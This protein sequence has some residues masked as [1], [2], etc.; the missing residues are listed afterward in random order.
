MQLILGENS[1]D[2]SNNIGELITKRA[3]E[4][5]DRTFYLVV[6][7][8]Y[9]LEA[10]KEMIRLSPNGCIINIDVVSL[11][12][13]AIRMVGDLGKNRFDFLSEEA[14]L[15]LTAKIGM[16]LEK[17]LGV[18]GKHVRKGGYIDNIKSTLC[19]LTQY[20]ISSDDIKKVLE[21][22]S[23]NLNPKLRNKLEDIL[24][25]KTEYELELGTNS[26][27]KE[28]FLI[29]ASE[30]INES[31]MFSDFEIYFDR[32]TGF[33][34][35]QIIFITKLLKASKFSAM[36]INYP[37]NLDIDQ[38]LSQTNIF[39]LSQ[40]T[41]HKI[42]EIC[43]LNY[44]EFL[45]PIR[46][47]NSNTNVKSFYF[48]TTTIRQ[49]VLKVKHEILKLIRNGYKYSDIGIV[50]LN[51]EGYSSVIKRVFD[52]SDI[53]LYMSDIG[54]LYNHS[55]GRYIISLLLMIKSNFAKATVLTYLKSG[56][57]DLTPQEII[58]LENYISATGKRGFK[59]YSE[60]FAQKP[61]FTR[62]M[63][64]DE[65]VDYFEKL[66]NVR[67][68]FINP[69]I[70]F[71]DEIRKAKTINEYNNAIIN[72]L[73]SINII[74]KISQIKLNNADVIDSVYA[75]RYDVVLS[76][77]V[78]IIDELDS[79]LGTENVSLEEYLVY[80]DLAFREIKFKAIPPS[81]DQI[82]CGDM[83]RTRFGN[84][85]ALFVL[86]VSSDN[87]PNVSTGSNVITDK[88]KS[89]LA[90]NKIKL[91][92]TAKEKIGIDNFYF[93]LHTITPTE[94]IYFSY[95]VC[96]KNNNLQTMSSA[97]TKYINAHKS[98]ELAY[99]DQELIT[100]DEAV[101]YIMKVLRNIDFEN[102][103]DS[104]KAYENLYT[105]L[106]QDLESRKKLK[107][108]L[109]GKAQVVFGGNLTKEKAQELF[110]AIIESS[111]TKL[112]D[113]AACPFKHY[114]KYGLRINKR[115]EFTYSHMDT[116]LI[117]HSVLQEFYYL[118]K[119]NKKQFRNLDNT[120]IE[121]YID[122]AL[123][124]VTTNYRNNILYSS[125]SNQYMISRI[126]KTL[127]FVMKF[128]RDRLKAGGFDQI[129]SEQKVEIALED[130]D[131][132]KMN[133]HGKIDR[134]DKAVI[135]D[136]H[137]LISIGDY[138]TGSKTFDGKDLYDGLDLQLPF[139]AYMLKESDKDK[140]ISIGAIEFLPLRDDSLKIDDNPN[141]TPDK[142]LE[143]RYKEIR[144]KGIINIGVKDREYLGLYAD[145]DDVSK[146][147]NLKTKKDG[148]FTAFSKNVSEGR[149]DT[150]LRFAK[151]KAL[152]LGKEIMSGK[153]KPE[154]VYELNSQS[155]EKNAPSIVC[156]YCPY[157]NIC[158]FDKNIATFNSREKESNNYSGLDI[159][160]QME[161]ELSGTTEETEKDVEYMN[162]IIKSIEDELSNEEKKK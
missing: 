20:N 63:S 74:D 39:K 120:E 58:L 102:D 38:N 92:P 31:D 72:H 83:K 86:G 145:P 79:I 98:K 117:M 143:D 87:L 40:N 77:I 127:N 75:D 118:I 70:P 135:N 151:D 11:K 160:D 125:Y 129:A 105:Y 19:E 43:D 126:R 13:L 113:F 6:P 95:A 2:L 21:D 89:L 123:D 49:E 141:I 27:T 4:F 136:D 130:D 30:L 119:N 107:L 8:Q 52:N 25:F 100:K 103:K 10:Q 159:I 157:G 17:E 61:D 142:I 148:G 150:V 154:P 138:K 134:V 76:K 71:R 37:S 161:K 50:Y 69:I 1:K 62:R 101:N 12:R 146:F 55:L 81:T 53:K 73:D 85:K 91:S 24:K 51:E 131:G 90:E 33:T 104:F 162:R 99:N 94:S 137:Y 7:E 121:E 139:Y 22:D 67:L 116:G 9:T 56:Y 15:F 158:K 28:Q 152:K 44:I 68:K 133:I 114:V 108:I 82:I 42:R 122:S 14:N 156:T 80:L 32:F 3:S 132:F 93:Y 65:L 109:D 106:A 128:H 140:N 29:K 149:M 153:I 96:E 5:P 54:T 124:N 46:L 23:S 59:N 110:G 66:N 35:D 155:G 48:E 78:E 18:L 112:S 88:E 34:P 41:I 16:K 111:I 60:V 115:E 84:I 47:K 26:I 45:E 97:V 144:G 57:L 36:T 147:Y 64:K